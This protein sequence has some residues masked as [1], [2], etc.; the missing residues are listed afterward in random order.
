[1]R[2][3]K[4]EFL[5]HDEDGDCCRYQSQSL[6]RETGQRGE[7]EDRHQ[8][9]AYMAKPVDR[10]HSTHLVRQYGKVEGHRDAAIQLVGSALQKES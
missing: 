5:P 7:P 4:V 6:E 10:L 8:F 9:K 1:M 3:T 2:S